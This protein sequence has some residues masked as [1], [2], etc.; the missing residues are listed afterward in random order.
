[1]YV[2]MKKGKFSNVNSVKNAFAKLNQDSVI[3]IK[4]SQQSDSILVFS[5]KIMHEEEFAYATIL[6][7]FLYG[8]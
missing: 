2:N 1:M 8:L 6:K 3:I 5:M 4:L 7:Y